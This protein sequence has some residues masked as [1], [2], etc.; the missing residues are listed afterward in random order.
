MTVPWSS[1]TR[2]LESLRLSSD[3]KRE[4]LIVECFNNI[5]MDMQL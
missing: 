1:G 4:I 3:G 5:I 2:G